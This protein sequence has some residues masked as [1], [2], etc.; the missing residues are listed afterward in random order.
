MSSLSF[1][2]MEGNDA[3]HKMIL[4]KRRLNLK[5]IECVNTAIIHSAISIMRFWSRVNSHS[6]SRLVGND[7][8]N[9][10]YTDIWR[11]LIGHRN[12]ATQKLQ[13][14]KQESLAEAERAMFG[15][16]QQPL[17]HRMTEIKLM[18]GRSKK[19]CYIS[20]V[21]TNSG[22]SDGSK[23]DLVLIHGCNDFSSC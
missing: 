6:V 11:R 7:S 10:A 23:P 14:K 17:E 18:A 12:G 19:P 3:I 21:S 15:V 13:T 4:L 9:E 16:V 1:K 2:D 22:R 5:G 20:S 8:L